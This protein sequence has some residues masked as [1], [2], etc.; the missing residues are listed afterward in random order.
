M[1]VGIGFDFHIIK[2]NIPMYIGGV[3]VNKKFGFFSNTDG[4][5]LIHSIVDAILG[6]IG[7][8]DIGEIFNEEWKGKRSIEILEN[9]VNILNMKN[10]EIVNLDAV[11]IL[12]KPKMSEFKEKIIENLSLI[13]KINKEKINIKFKTMEKV[14]IIGKSKG[15][16][17]FAVVL[18][19]EKS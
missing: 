18:V 15:G 8:K 3:L 5:I 4:D 12:E 7:E 13:M 2:K 11:I 16:A 10:Y 17:S 14:G 19:K 6:A 1:R 9:T